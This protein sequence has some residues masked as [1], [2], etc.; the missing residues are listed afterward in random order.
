MIAADQTIVDKITGDCTRA[1]IA[2]MLDLEIDAVPH[3]ARFEDK[4]FRS[5]MWFRVMTSFLK[6]FGYKYFG[7]GWVLSEDRPH[8]QILNESPNINGFVMATVQSRTFEGVGHSVVMNLEGL[9]VH[10]PNP[11]RLWQGINVIETKDLQHWMMIGEN[12]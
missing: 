11:N 3:F 9:V 6:E 1:C 2:S 5:D 12:E 8:G 7:T 10:D 4:R